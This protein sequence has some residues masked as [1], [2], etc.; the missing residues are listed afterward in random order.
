MGVV[1]SRSTPYHA[2]GF[3]ITEQFNQTLLGMLGMLSNTDKQNWK[4]HVST[5]TRAYN[6]I[7]HDVTGY[8]QYFLMHGHHPRL[9]VDIYLGLVTEDEQAEDMDEY[10]RNWQHSLDEAYQ[11]V[12]LR[13][14]KKCLISKSYYDRKA[15]QSELS[16]GDR[17]LVR[18]VKVRGK[19]KLADQWE[20]DPFVIVRQ[21]DRGIPVYVVKPERGGKVR[22][23]HRNLLPFHALSRPKKAR[24][25]RR[26]LVEPVKRARKPRTRALH[27][28]TQ[29]SSEADCDTEDTDADSDR[30]YIITYPHEQCA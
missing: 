12:S 30:G 9:P 26:E 21:D 25:M 14:D 18:N 23:L 2:Q 19:H 16:P 22:N 28:T 3:G 20:R 24:P 27:R 10:V 11:I 7:K 13:M 6:C 17:V 4:Q 29:A 5:V 1:K 15:R 8:T